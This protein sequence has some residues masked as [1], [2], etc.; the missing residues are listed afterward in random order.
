MLPLVM[1]ILGSL[2]S[3]YYIKKGRRK[4]KMMFDILGIIGCSLAI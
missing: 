3:G 1:A 4:P 2:M